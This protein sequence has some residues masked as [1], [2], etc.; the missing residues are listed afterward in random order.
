MLILTLTLEYVSHNNNNNIDV[1]VLLY[2]MMLVRK[3]LVIASSMLMITLTFPGRHVG[4][5]ALPKDTTS[6]CT[7]GNQTGNLL[8]IARFPNRSAIWP[9]INKNCIGCTS[10]STGK[11]VQCMLEF[12]LPL[13]LCRLLNFLWRYLLCYSVLFS[14]FHSKPWPMPV[15]LLCR[16]H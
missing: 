6:F 13:Q 14:P 2:K 15:S 9:S 1:V 10:G 8:L 5:S 11:E 3:I 7:A 4:W 16:T 12:M